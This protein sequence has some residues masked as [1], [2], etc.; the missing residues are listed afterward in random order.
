M[1]LPKEVNMMIFQSKTR[2][3]VI[4]LLL[5]LLLFIPLVLVGCG[6]G[7]GGG[8]SASGG[9]TS[10]NTGPTSSSVWNYSDEAAIEAILTKNDFG[11]P[12]ASDVGVVTEVVSMTH[13]D[14]T[15]ATVTYNR[16]SWVCMPFLT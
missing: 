15:H 7:G 3:M 14:A 11:T 12:G 16:T 2:F 13:T 8:S 9:S 4:S 6:S 10:G 1:K 5:L